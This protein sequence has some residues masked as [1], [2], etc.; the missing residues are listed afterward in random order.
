MTFQVQAPC[1]TLTSCTD[2]VVS[3]EQVS[4]VQQMSNSWPRSHLRLLCILAV[5]SAALPYKT[6]YCSLLRLAWPYK[7]YT[8]RQRPEQE[9]IKQ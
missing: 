8:S 9:A 7:Q 6:I 1:V 5:C 2:P 3:H 4:H